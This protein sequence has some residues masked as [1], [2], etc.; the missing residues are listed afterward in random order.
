MST[1]LH[2]LYTLST[3]PF[4]VLENTTHNTHYAVHILISWEREPDKEK[5]REW[6]VNDTK[7]SQNSSRLDL[8]LLTCFSPFSVVDFWKPLQTPMNGSNQ[9][10][11]RKEKKKTFTWRPERQN[12]HRTPKQC[13]KPAP[14]CQP[15]SWTWQSNHWQPAHLTAC[16]W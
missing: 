10:P 15:A 16:W 3:K 12:P 9:P 4:I 7:T 14:T 2:V 1:S 6:G 5:F 11:K 8:D 13:L